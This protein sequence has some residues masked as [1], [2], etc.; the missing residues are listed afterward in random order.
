MGRRDEPELEELS[1][2]LRRLETMEVTPKQSA[3]QPE[4]EPQAEYVGA[5]RGAPP[6]K[7]SEQRHG[8]SFEAGHARNLRSGPSA[9]APKGASTGTSAIILGAAT[10]AVVSSVVAIGIVVWS[11]GEN[12][13]GASRLTFYA[14]QEQTS[15]NRPS[16]AEPAARPG[17]NVAPSPVEAQ[18]LLQR[19]DAYLRSGKPEDARLV[20]EQAARAGS[21]VAALTLGAMYDPGRVAQFA[22][23]GIQPDPSVARAWYERAK[24][25]GVAE[26]NDRLAELAAR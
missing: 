8:A 7:A 24:D 5:L 9:A 1:K 4:A 22:K 16:G 10:A 20:L 19:A 11:A 15:G 3:R 6:A 26:A 14:P 13:D 18:Q 12:S 23:L 25:L 2:L 17:T 21:G